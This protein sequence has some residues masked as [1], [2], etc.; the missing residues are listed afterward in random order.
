MAA[1]AMATV[2]R[3]ASKPLI[4]VDAVISETPWIVMEI[5]GLIASC[6]KAKSPAKR[7]RQLSP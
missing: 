2:A 4:V 5:A 1:P 3:P 6:S 7:I